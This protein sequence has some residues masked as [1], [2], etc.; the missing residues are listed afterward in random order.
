MIRAVV[1]EDEPLAAQYLRALLHET[2]KV[3]V[4]GTAQEGNF[5]LQLCAEQ[6]PDAAF[7]DIHLPGPDGLALAAHLTRL[8]QPPLIVFT[9][10]H[11]D[12][13]CDA[14]RIEAVDYLLKPLEPTQVREAVA[15]LESRLTPRGNETV[16][17][18]EARPTSPLALLNDRL[19]VKN[20]SD[21]VIKLL[22]RW[23][24]VAALHHDRR[25]WIHT[26][27]EEFATYYPLAELL[28]WLGEP[29]FL[30]IS[31]EAILNL[32]AIEEII[33]YGD[34]LY[35]VRLRDRQK[36]RVEASRSGASRL[37]SLLKSSL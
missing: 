15:R 8:P 33:H 20:G 24:I 31:R 5:G 36:T 4:V 26:T 23:E 12:R 19:P 6:R 21:D 10:G 35:Q 22:S 34:R 30:R 16:S 37:S 27:Q 14:F 17:L 9:T 25:T 3:E 1:V 18:A 13:A 29:A 7:L 2:G 32:Q 28:R 11:A